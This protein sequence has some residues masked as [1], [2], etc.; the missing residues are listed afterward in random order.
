MDSGLEL[1]SS[2][3]G[4]AGA[5]RLGS[6]GQSS[7]PEGRRLVTTY[8]TTAL[9]PSSGSS[10]NLRTQREMRTLAEAL[11]AILAG[12]LAGAGDLLMQRFRALEMATVDGN[13]DMARHL[14][15]IPDTAVSS[16]T[17]GM[18]KEAL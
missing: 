3:L 14:E 17:V 4:G 18:R 11:D 16:V 8:L 7:E 15:L 10:M 13:W 2:Y 9:L 12:D 5:A 1:M 6:S